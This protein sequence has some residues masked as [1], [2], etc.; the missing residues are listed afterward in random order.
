MSLVGPLRLERASYHCWATALAGEWCHRLKHQ[1]GAAL[2]ATREALDR[3]GR[4][5]DV[6][7]RHRQ[8]AGYVRGNV[9]RRDSPR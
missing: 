6:R 1:G 7:E 5:A 3:R 2:S 9:P 4:K 8:V